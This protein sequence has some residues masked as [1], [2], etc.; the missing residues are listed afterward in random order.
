MGYDLSGNNPTINEQK[1]KEMK[2]ILEVWGDDIGWGLDWN[3]KIPEHIKD[4]YWELEDQHRENNPGI[5]FRANVWWWRPIWN[6]VV[7]FCDDFL[8]DADLDKGYSNDS[9][10]ISKTKSKKIAARL[11]RTAK[12]GTMDLWVKVHQER[13]DKAKAHNEIIEKKLHSLQEQCREAV[14]DMNIVPADYPQPFKKRWDMLYSQKDWNSSYPCNKDGLLEFERFC[15]ESGG[16]II[17]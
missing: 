1:P 4:K 15:E 12:D 9:L 13:Y 5:Y 11:R 2:D 16:F 7:E 17:S 10:G 8:T 14:G 3:K 6:Y